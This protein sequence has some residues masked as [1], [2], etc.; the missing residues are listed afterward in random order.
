MDMRAQTSRQLVLRFGGASS[1]GVKPANQDAFAAHQPA[2]CECRLKG[3]VACIADGLSCSEQAQLASQTAVTQFIEDYYSTPDSW[4]VKTAAARV[5]SSMNAWFF[6]QGQA[7]A[8]PHHGLVT[9]FSA[10]ICKSTTAHLFHVGDSRIYRLRGDQLEQ[11]T[12]D[13]HTGGSSNDRQTWLSRALGADSRLEVDYLQCELREGDIFLL[14]TDG[15]HEFVDEQCM[16]EIAGGGAGGEQAAEAL[17]DAALAHGGG[18]NLSALLVHVEQLPRQAIDEVHRELT[19][20]IIP[21]VLQPGMSID[22]FQVLRVLHNGTR[23]H[24]YLVSDSSS[25]QFVLKAPSEN[26]ADDAQYLE[27]FIREGWVGRRMD[28]PR[29]MIIHRQKNES[30]F[31]YHLCEHVGGTT[32]RQWMYDNPTPSLQKVRELA[33]GIVSSLRVLQ[34]AGMVHRDLKPENIMLG[35]QGQIKLVD[36]GTVMVPGLEEIESPLQEEIPVGSVDYAAPEYVLGVDQQRSDLFSLGVIVYE[37]LCGQLPFSRPFGRPVPSRYSD[38][39]YRSINQFR[40]D[41]PSW[42]D[43]VLRKALQADP[44]QRYEPYSE[45]ISNLH[46]PSR[47][48]LIASNN[49]PLLERSPLRV[50]QFLSAALFVLVLLQ[51]YLLAT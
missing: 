6:H 49:A 36:F 3:A 14:T 46:K 17:V 19:G 33:A 50:W 42:I 13:H 22:G 28:H 27:S 9:T 20:K 39:Q 38:W 31:L 34:R 26:F 35:D 48:M 40:K 43:L 4:S 23:S 12:R 5:L 2:P 1:A 41:L 29:I 10:I 30:P 25:K 21:P 51:F 45:L 37:L 7:S 47:E 24:V 18:D 32:L 8:Q 44:R 11:L 15:L 16:R